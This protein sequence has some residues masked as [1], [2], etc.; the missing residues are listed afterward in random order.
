MIFPPLDNLAQDFRDNYVKEYPQNVRLIEQA[1]ENIVNEPQRIAQNVNARIMGSITYPATP[2]RLLGVLDPLQDLLIEADYS[3]FGLAKRCTIG[4]SES[5]EEISALYFGTH[6][7]YG[8]EVGDIVFHYDGILTGLDISFDNVLKEH[9]NP[10]SMTNLMARLFQS[11]QQND[12]NDGTFGV[13]C[14]DYVLKL[15]YP[16]TYGLFI[17]MIE[18]T[19]WE[20]KLSRACLIGE[21]E[22]KLRKKYSMP[23]TIKVRRIVADGMFDDLI[24]QREVVS[25]WASGFDSY[26]SALAEIHDITEQHRR[27][28]D[29]L[30]GYLEGRN[31]MPEDFAPF[32]DGGIKLRM[33]PM[34]RDRLDAF[35]RLEYLLVKE[36]HFARDIL[37]H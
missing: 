12:M 5:G 28:V 37:Q 35:A 19:N 30:S 2:E 3:H 20:E 4:R 33:L 7:L 26:E 25:D 1:I 14:A 17:P 9:Q 22:P 27:T 13:L 18:S 11:A 32:T 10:V 24:M 21:I 16:E 15:I 8:A 36:E 6:A 29:G 31:E 34:N 23:P